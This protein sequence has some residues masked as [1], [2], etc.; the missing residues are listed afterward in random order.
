MRSEFDPNIDFSVSAWD[1]RRLMRQSIPPLPRELID[2]KQYST[3]YSTARKNARHRNIDFELTREEFYQ[4]VRESKE[5]CAIS[6][7]AFNFTYKN[8]KRRPFAPSL[9][10]INSAKGYSKQ[11]CRVISLIANLALNEWGEA[12]L[13]KFC[14]AVFR[15]RIEPT[16]HSPQ[17]SC[18]HQGFLMVAEMAL[19]NTKSP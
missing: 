10:R 14:K 1:R 6:G 13:L 16:S 8:G 5:R 2:L 4:L 17:Q 3:I 12:S 7:I 11:N 15:L 9:D 19:N 18:N